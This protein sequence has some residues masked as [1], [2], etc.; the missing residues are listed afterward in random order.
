MTMPIVGL[1]LTALTI[2]LPSAGHLGPVCSFVG[3]APVKTDRTAY[4]VG[5]A[6]ADTVLA[7]PDGVDFEIQRGHFGPATERPVHGQLVEVE[8]FGGPAAP[9]VAEHPVALVVP[10]DYAADCATTPWTRNARFLKVGKRGFYR[11]A[12]REREHWVEGIPTFDA[13]TPQFEGF[14]HA[15]DRWA[16]RAR[17][18]GRPLLSAGEL[19]ELYQMIPRREEIEE[20]HWDAVEPVMA[21]ARS[22]PDR[23][24]AY[25]AQ[26]IVHRLARRADDERAKGLSVPVAG[27][28][29]V[30]VRLPSGSTE[31]FYLRTAARP[32]GA[33]HPLRPPDQE[34]ESPPPPWSSTSIGYEVYFWHGRELEELPRDSAAAIRSIRGEWPISIREEPRRKGSLRTWTGDF[35]VPQ[36]VRSIPDNPELRAAVDE[37]KREF[38]ERWQAGEIRLDPVVFTQAPSGETEFELVVRLGPDRRLR[39]L[40]ERVS[41]RTVPGR[42]H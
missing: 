10:W 26:R 40:G 42:T 1:I 22:N 31:V 9:D 19:F 2:S 11:P 37:W 7:G 17:K 23:L 28:Y 5:K 24:K 6:L 13:F 20:S 25:P 39:V 35:E 15:M 16:R 30:E 18:R 36:L 29:R 32:V 41:P 12:L 8:R 33:W 14:P 4:F 21:W 27:T 3:H 38:S 34:P